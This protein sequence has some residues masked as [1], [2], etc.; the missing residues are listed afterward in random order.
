MEH[1]LKSAWYNGSDVKTVVKSLFWNF[2]VNQDLIFYSSQQTIW[3]INKTLGQIPTVV[4]SAAED[5]YAIWIYKHE[6]M[7]HIQI[8]GKKVCRNIFKLQNNHKN[9]L[10]IM[11]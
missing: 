4:H 11:R 7:I 3:K 8:S 5:V 1:D 9:V 10:K 2:A 6:G